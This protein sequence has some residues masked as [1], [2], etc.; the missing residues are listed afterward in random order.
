MAV[1]LKRTAAVLRIAGKSVLAQTLEKRG[2]AIEDGIWEYGVVNHKK[3]GEVFAFEVDGYGSHI[4]M[5]DANVP[6][7]LALPILGFVDMNDLVYKNTRKM[8]LEQAGNPYYLQGEGFKGIGGMFK[9]LSC[10]SIKVGLHLPGPHIG[11]E[12]AWPMSL[13][14]QA[15]TTDDDKEIKKSLDLVLSASKLG[16]IHESKF[17][18]LARKAAKPVLGRI[19]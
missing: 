3:Y 17:Q 18:G 5:D 8:I 1:E 7:L 16:L 9:S 4:M 11:Y 19:Y 15:M 10:L 6:S 14:L 12:H 13:L 2:Q